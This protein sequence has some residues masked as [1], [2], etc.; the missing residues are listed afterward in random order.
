[1]VNH[2][3]A[4]ASSIVAYAAA[5]LLSFVVP[6]TPMTAQEVTQGQPPMATPLP[7]M[8]RT[9]E[10]R[11]N[12]EG[13]W[14]F[15]T[16]TPLERP[17]RFAG[18]TT[19]T[20]QEAEE[21]VIQTQ[22]ARRGSAFAAL[23]V[24][25]DFEQSARPFVVVGGRKP[26]SLIFDPPDGRIPALTPEAQERWSHLWKG[27]RADGP[28]DR[29]LPERCLRGDAGPPMLPNVSA[30]PFEREVMSPFVRIIQ[31]GREIVFLQEGFDGARM[32][33]LDGR[34]H[35]SNTIRSF[36]GDSRGRWSG[37]V[38]IVDTTNFRDQ[39]AQRR[40]SNR[41]DR[42]LHV[43]E[44]LSVVNRDLLWYEFTVEDPTMFAKAWSG[45][46]PMRRTDVQLYE[47]ACHEGNEGMFNILR[48]ARAGELGGS[49]V[50]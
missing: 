43:V 48:G 35:V 37:D 15:A 49:S 8:V 1:M 46:F 20:D 29:L 13:V 3:P 45:A 11:P 25:Q 33:P 41:F 36:L 26:T 12:L 50:Q 39:A 5:I 38:L 21:Y 9:A 14:T 47:V 16:A 23:G 28:Q 2:M 40:V 6:K 19:M 27:E 17:A 10:G 22:A 24:A 18:K 32:I 31:T 7:G 44:R 4:R 34:A 42:N 30:S